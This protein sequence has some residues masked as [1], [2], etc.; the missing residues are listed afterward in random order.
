MKKRV[1]ALLLCAVMALS[2]CACGD[3]N[4]GGSANKG[5][6]SSEVEQPSIKNLVSY[7]DLTV[8]LKGDYEINDKV[9]S[10]AF[11]SLIYG[12]G[13]ELIEVKD[14]NV[15]QAGDIVL[16]AFSGTPNEELAKTLTEK[17]LET[18]QGNMST[19]KDTPALIDVSNNGVF[20]EKTGQLTGS[21]ISGKWG[22][23][24][25]GLIGAKI[26]EPKSSEVTFP[27]PYNSDK[28]LSGQKATFTFT[29]EK[30]Y[31]QLTLDT[32]TDAQVKE[33]LEKEYKLTTVKDAVNYVKEQLTVQALQSY[34]YN[35]CEVTIPSEYLDA[36]LREYEAY[37]TE[38]TGAGDKLETWLKTYYG[39]TLTE[40]RADWAEGLKNQIK[41]EVIYEEIVKGK[42][43]K[44]DEEG[45]AEYMEELLDAD[46]SQFD[47]EED[48]YMYVGAG[49]EDKGK[50]YMLNE[51]AVLE[52]FKSIYQAS[53]AETK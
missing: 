25:D 23:F 31:T 35:K 12:A 36:R 11:T 53:I 13:A 3:D 27:D 2:V 51:T 30:I 43:L 20:D 19:A 50:A 17:E 46:N 32:I 7:D 47:Y 44:L 33:L 15:V 34:V 41:I 39:V 22:K 49:V 10:N 5:K 8:V 24:T 6:P 42:N 26:G 48:V 28:R 18:M 52:H 4:G 1:L 21:Y 40:A 9:I 38:L 37:F 16:T 45:H 14:R 29:V